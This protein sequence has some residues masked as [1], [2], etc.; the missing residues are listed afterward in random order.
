MA[1]IAYLSWFVTIFITA[2][3]YPVISKHFC[4]VLMFKISVILFA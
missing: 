4:A 1:D 3:H 2:Q